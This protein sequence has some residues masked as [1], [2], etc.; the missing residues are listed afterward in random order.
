MIG[1]DTPP[2]VGKETQIKPGQVLNPN[3]RPKGALSWSTVV[4]ELLEDETLIEK[5]VKNPPA[6]IKTLNRKDAA[7]IIAISMI[8]KAVSGDKQAADWLR[9]TGFGDQLDINVNKLEAAQASVEE[10]AAQDDDV[11]EWAKS[12]L[13]E[14]VK[15]PEVATGA[16]VQDKGQAGPDSDLPAESDPAQIPGQPEE[17][18]LQPDPQS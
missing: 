18:P 15:R 13:A 3:G 11:G 8:A 14:T 1:R 6:Y 9:K 16:S 4:K 17:P 12:Q 5:I 10:L 2:S 7:S